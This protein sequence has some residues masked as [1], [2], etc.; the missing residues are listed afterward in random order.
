M[1]NLTSVIHALCTLKYITMGSTMRTN[2]IFVLVL[3]S[4]FETIGKAFLGYVILCCNVIFQ[5]RTTLITL[6]S[7]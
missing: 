1:Y 5:F 4:I 2:E 6:I 3:I 7:L